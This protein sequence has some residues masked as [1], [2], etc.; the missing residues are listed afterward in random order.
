MI[1]TLAVLAAGLAA[2]GALFVALLVVRRLQL[3]RRERGRAELEERLRPVAL[4]AVA[5]EAT[6]VGA[7]DNREVFG[8]V[9]VRP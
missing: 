2:A 7:L 4:A 6:G 8:K 9:V 5:G 3:G 1:A